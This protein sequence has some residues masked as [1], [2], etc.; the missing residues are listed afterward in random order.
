EQLVAM[1]AQLP[2]PPFMGLW[3]RLRDFSRDAMR[4]AFHEKRIVRGTALRGT[5]HVLSARDYR[6]FRPV[7]ASML[8]S[9]ARSI[10]DKRAVNMTEE[11]S[12]VVGRA[13]F[14]KAAPFDDFRKHL[15]ARK[16]IG[17]IRAIAYTVR[18]G[19]P[20]VMVPDEDAAWAFSSSAGFLN[21]DAW[22]GPDLAKPAPLETLVTRYLAAFG[23]ATPGDAQAW[24]GIRGLRE[25]FEALRPGLVTFRDARKRELFDLPDAPRPAADTPA[26]I[27]FLPE[28]DNVLLGHDDRTRIIADAHRPAVFLKNLQVRGTFLVDGF[29]AGVWRVERKKKSATLALTP[30]VRITKPAKT[31]L[32]REGSSLLGFLEP[33]T[34]DASVTWEK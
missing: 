19:I 3:T 32:E 34:K 4:R 20:L 28:F 22:L 17:D 25:T 14:A 29:V 8:V 9:G 30:F 23:P 18:M 6:R 2:R 12:Y 5:I 13:F 11:E 27:R 15:E 10:V 26:P 31:E 24:S 7:L 16:E 1:Q 21:A 33:D